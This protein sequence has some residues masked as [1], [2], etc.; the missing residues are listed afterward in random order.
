MLQ[1]DSNMTYDKKKEMYEKIMKELS[2]RVKHI[3]FEDSAESTVEMPYSETI[4]NIIDKFINSTIS[5]IKNIQPQELNTVLNAVYENHLTKSKYPEATWN[6][7]YSYDITNSLIEHRDVTPTDFETLKRKLKRAHNLKDWQFDSTS[8][9]EIGSD[10]INFWSYYDVL[11]PSQQV[12]S[13]IISNLNENIDIVSKDLEYHGYVILRAMVTEAIPAQYGKP[14]TCALVIFTSNNPLNVRENIGKFL[15][16]LSLTTNRN[17]ILKNG[18]IKKERNG[19]QIYYNGRV[20][21]FT[22]DFYNNALDYSREMSEAYQE[23]VD[24]YTVNLDKLP[25]D[26]TFHYDP[27]IGPSAIYTEHSIPSEAIIDVQKI[28]IQ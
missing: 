10:N 26:W 3:L 8:I 6:A 24:I 16:H 17:N 28:E 9:E 19:E 13:L 12:Y 27:L 25:S 1:I 18:I 7:M 15:C 22:E 4:S 2:N 23:S 14:M 11:N 20:F 5:K 21:F